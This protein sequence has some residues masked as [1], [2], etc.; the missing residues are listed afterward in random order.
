MKLEVYEDE[1]NV[2]LC[3]LN[4]RSACLGIARVS[5]DKK[6]A[7][8]LFADLFD[9]L[10][11]S[12]EAWRDWH[13]FENAGLVYDRKLLSGCLLC[14]WTDDAGMVCISDRTSPVARAIIG[15][16]FSDFYEDA[17]CPDIDDSRASGLLDE[18]D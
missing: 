15:G 16:C 5:K 17:G 13:D 4:D 3:V 1:L 12:P 8:E 6:N 18:E 14:C 9:Q 11:G 2:D 7:R 10:R